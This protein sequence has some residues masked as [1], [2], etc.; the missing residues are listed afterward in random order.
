MN[1]EIYLK[2]TRVSTNNKFTWK[3]FAT[4]G[5]RCFCDWET[6]WADP[7]LWPIEPWRHKRRWRNRNCVVEQSSDIYCFQL[8]TLDKI[9]CGRAIQR[10]WLFV[11]WD[12]GLG[13]MWSRTPVFVTLDPGKP[14]M[15]CGLRYRLLSITF[16][17]F[18]ILQQKSV[19]S[20]HCWLLDLP[21]DLQG[22]VNLLCF[23]GVTLG[24]TGDLYKHRNKT[25]SRRRTL[26]IVQIL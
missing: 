20:L 6:M 2:T 26:F 25:R 17:L 18:I 19:F 23:S 10:Y 13:I 3:Q 8:N 1:S 24:G 12:F 15:P 22:G 14:V 4:Q 16:E 7:A 11:N 5:N 9:L 21:P